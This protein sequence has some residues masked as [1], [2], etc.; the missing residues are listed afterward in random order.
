MSSTL[1]SS[2]NLGRARP[3]P[4]LHADGRS[5]LLRKPFI[6]APALSTARLSIALPVGHVARG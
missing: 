3:N 5:S 2:M 4:R 1:R 6:C